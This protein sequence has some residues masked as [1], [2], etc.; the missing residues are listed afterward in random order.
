VDADV[1]GSGMGLIF[2]M[3][4]KTP[5]IHD[6]LSGDAKAEDIVL[7]STEGVELAVG[8]VRIEALRDINIK[9]LK[10]FIKALAGKYEVVLVDA[11][12]GLGVDTITAISACDT[13]LLVVAPDILSVSEALK[14]K[15]IVE[16]LG[17]KVVGVVVNRAGSIYDIPTKYIEDMV[18][19]KVLATIEEAEEVKKALMEGEVL[20]FHAPDSP[21][22]KSI[23]K[24][25]EE[26]VG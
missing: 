13:V 12:S 14:S 24:L 23:I 6:F 15:V 9:L 26:L 21:V 5:T 17:S 8:S 4:F 20:L 10:N 19:V 7:K 25:A 2:G 22:A 1:E 3:N 18:G 16:R 11:P